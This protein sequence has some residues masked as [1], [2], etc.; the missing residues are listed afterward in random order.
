MVSIST[1]SLLLGFFF[2]QTPSHSIYY[3]LHPKEK[4]LFPLAFPVQDFSSIIAKPFMFPNLWILMWYLQPSLPLHF[5][6]ASI[7]TLS[8]DTW[9]STTEISCLYVFSL[10]LLLTWHSVVLNSVSMGT[11]SYF[12]SGFSTLL[13]HLL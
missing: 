1:K 5:T 10:I 13:D 2:S 4:S 3:F 7:V 12:H 8:Q 9:P 6:S 11:I